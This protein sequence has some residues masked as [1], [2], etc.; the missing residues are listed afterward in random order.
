LATAYFGDLNRFYAILDEDV[1]RACVDTIYGND[2]SRL[3]VVDYCMFY[4]VVSIGALG[5]RKAS[6]QTDTFS[7]L[8]IDAH[9]KAWSMIHDTMASPCEATVQVLLLLVC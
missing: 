1:F 3:G 4:L 8:T 2:R 5:S 9:H 7:R 6:E